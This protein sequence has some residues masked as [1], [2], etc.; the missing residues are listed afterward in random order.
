MGTAEMYGSSYFMDEDV[1]LVTVT[2]R[3][4]IMGMFQISANIDLI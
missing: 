4:G 1:V 3:V 2:Y